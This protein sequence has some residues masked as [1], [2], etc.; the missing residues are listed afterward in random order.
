MK[1]V[2]DYIKSRLPLL[3][4]AF[5]LITCAVAS[6]VYGKYVNNNKSEADIDVTAQGV[7]TIS[8]T[9][10][11]TEQ[12]GTY[13]YTI[14]NKP[15]SAD[16][17][18]SNIPAYIRAAIVVNWQDAEGNLW[19]SPPVKDKDYVISSNCVMI[20]DYYY[21]KGE[22]APG[23]AFPITVT[24]TAN[25]TPPAGCTLHVKILAEGIQCMP[26]NAVENAWGMKYKGGT[27]VEVTP[28]S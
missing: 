24:L 11:E 4:L 21:Y 5:C 16:S 15:V 13:E 19:A 18:G 25:A 9:G 8:V 10:G 14:T 26:A 7:L 12:A 27:W 2:W 20:G 23:S 3:L 6:M 1:F 28:Q 17:E 22:C